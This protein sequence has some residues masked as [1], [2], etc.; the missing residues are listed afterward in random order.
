MMP[1]DLPK[2]V[3]RYK[4]R[5]GQERIYFRLGNGHPYHRIREEVG[6]PEFWEAYALLLKRETIFEK[7]NQPIA[8]AILPDSFRWLCSRYANSVEFKKRD[9]PI[10]DACCLEPIAPRDQRLF[11]DL[12]IANL[13][14]QHLKVLRDRKVKTGSPEAA[15][16]RIKSLKRLCR[17]A[18]GAGT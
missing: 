14:L 17:W 8:P 7:A 2:H 3:H 9:K 13:T 15:N 12:P 11:A 10:L 18:V 6:S 16:S 5:H 4:S 1:R